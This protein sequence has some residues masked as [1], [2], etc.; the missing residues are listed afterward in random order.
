MCLACAV[1]C[2]HYHSNKMGK[3]VQLSSVTINFI[4]LCLF[5]RKIAFLLLQWCIS[6]GGGVAGLSPGTAYIY[7]YIHTHIYNWMLPAPA[8]SFSWFDTFNPLKG[9]LYD[10]DDLIQIKRIMNT[11]HCI[12]PC[13]HSSFN[14]R[15]K[16]WKGSIYL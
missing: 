6:G 5:L 3:V 16:M 2:E 11:Q 10:K 14:P 15:E 13:G 4:L 7:I 12:R 8:L 1:I 9:A